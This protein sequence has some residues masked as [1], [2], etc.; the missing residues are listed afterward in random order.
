MGFIRGLQALNEQRQEQLGNIEN[1]TLNEYVKEMCEEENITTF[2][3][4]IAFSSTN[5]AWFKAMKNVMADREADPERGVRLNAGAL[6]VIQQP[7]EEPMFLPAN[8]GKGTLEILGGLK[9]NNKPL[10]K[11]DEEYV[12]RWINT[13]Y[14]N[15]KLG[16][17]EGTSDLGE[18]IL[19]IVHENARGGDVEQSHIM[20]AAKA[21]GIMSDNSV[22]APKSASTS[23]P[24][25]VKADTNT[26]IAPNGA[27][28]SIKTILDKV[29]PNGTEF[30]QSKLDKV[31]AKFTIKEEEN[32]EMPA[33]DW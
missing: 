11:A 28:V 14:Q 12:L 33:F 29:F 18:E 19:T 23:V 24:A 9:I 25:S 30:N 8:I 4:Y 22:P 32:V 5:G 15:G 3:S 10:T 6:I 17:V 2:K 13:E 20:R 27:E 16:F 1:K 31:L 7:N 26:Y 21:A